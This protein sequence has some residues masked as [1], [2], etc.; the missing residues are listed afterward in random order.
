MSSCVIGLSLYSQSY[1]LASAAYNAGPL[2][3]REWR[4]ALQKPM[5]GAIFIES[6]P[7]FET[8]DYVKNVLSNTF[9][10]ASLLNEDLGSFSDFVGT[11][12]PANANRPET[13]LP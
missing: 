11:I 9:T 2:R 4:K 3:A 5:E 12:H 6:I 7:F 1:A 10:Y 8:R 13:K